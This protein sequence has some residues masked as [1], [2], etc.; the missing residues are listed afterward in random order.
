M[1]SVSQEA[2]AEAAA[3]TR[4]TPP[5]RSLTLRRVRAAASLAIS[6]AVVAVAWWLLAPPQLGGSTSFATV[7]GTSMLPSLKR[8]DLVALRPAGGYRVG[9]IVAYHSSLLHRV[10]LHRI[11]AIQGGQYVFKGDNNTFLDPDRPSRAQLVG[12][13]WFHLP[14]AGK[15]IGLLHVPW[16]VALIAGLL[17]MAVGLGGSKNRP[18]GEE[19]TDAPSRNMRT[20]QSR[21]R[22]GRPT[23]G[24]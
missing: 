14:A 3:W 4:S 5:A 15:A 2:V 20:T 19:L 10:V 11:V 6:I 17:V 13:L 18:G 21:A 9:D 16:V 22:P 1:A 24:G 23:P 7:D 8:S 12:K